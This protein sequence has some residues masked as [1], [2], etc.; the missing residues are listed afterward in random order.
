MLKKWLKHA[1]HY[2]MLLVLFLLVTPCMVSA[3]SNSPSSGTPDGTPPVLTGMSLSATTVTAPGSLEVIISGTD[4]VSGVNYGHVRFYCKE[5]GRSLSTSVYPTYWDSDAGK[6]LPYPDGN[7]HGTLS[8]AQYLES[9]TF[10]LEYISLTDHAGNSQSY[11]SDPYGSDIPIPDF[12]IDREIRVT[13]IDTPDSTPPVLTGMTVSS[14]NITAS[15]SLE[16]IISGTDDISG[17]NYGHVRFYCK[18]T[19]RSL[20]TSVYPTYWDS[21]EGRELPY[22]DGNF[23]GKLTANQYLE[24]GTFVLEYISLTDHAGN[25]QSYYSDP[26]GSDI[27]IPDFVTQRTLILTAGDNPDSTPPVLTGMTVTTAKITAPGTLEVIMS[28][29]DDVSGINYGHVRYYCKETGKSISSSVYPTYW[30][31]D[32]GKELPYPDGNLHGTLSVNQYLESGTFVLDYISLTDY[33]GNSQSYYSEP[34]GNDKPIPNFVTSRQI[35]VLNA[36]PDVATSVS[37]ADFVTQLENQKNDAYIVADYSGNATLPSD[38]F[39]AIAGTNKTL[40][41]VSD[42]V[43]WRFNGNDIQN[44]S[45]PIELN[46]VIDTIEEHP[47]DETDDILETTDSKPAIVMQFPENGQLPGAATIQVK[48]D[49]VMREYLG[50]DRNLSVY[51]FNNQTGELELVAKNL[52]I[53]SDTFVEF[54]ITH[55]SHY[56]LIPDETVFPFLDVPNNIWY[57]QPVKWAVENSITTGINATLFGPEDPCTRGQCVTFLWRAAGSPEP[58]AANNPFTDVK[59]E[60]YYYKAVLW[61]VENKITTGTSSTTFSPDNKCTRGEIVTFLWRYK[62]APAV[63]SSNNFTDVPAGEFYTNP[64]TWAVNNGVTTGINKDRFA[65]YDTCTR[66]QI[67]TFLYRVAK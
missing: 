43:T 30:D 12:V 4:D 55:C 59:S 39:D 52:S 3:T 19:G 31:S 54:T 56:V 7:F 6:E 22:P 28:A 48:L 38:A 32:A 21:E 66:A 37:N 13:S 18:E 67:V 44:S 20:S 16:V 64:V 11:Y 23:H 46:V 51:Y 47:S 8:A 63:T 40:D 1:S 61:A 24:S 60:E 45:K 65:P 36:V 42:G 34:Y 14:T 25:S 33:A 50:S 62:G 10:V 5:T 27:P 15:G 9:G 17:I 57:L 26:Y 49:H 53:I 58:S 35:K 2:F 29:T 41:L